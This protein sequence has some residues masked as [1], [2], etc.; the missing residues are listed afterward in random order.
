MKSWVKGWMKMKP[1]D[2]AKDWSPMDC[3][4]CMEYWDRQPC[5]AA[6]CASVGI[7][8]GKSMEQMLFEFF[9]SFH[10]RGHKK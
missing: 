6:A 3:P 10:E 5:L 2:A 1:R 8:H 7:E 4:K 9:E